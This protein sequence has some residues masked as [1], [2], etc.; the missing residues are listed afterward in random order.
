MAGD[1]TRSRRFSDW[2]GLLCFG[3]LAV[4]TL[5]KMTIASVMLIPTLVHELL[6]GGAFLIR[7]VPRA[8]IR[9]AR[10]RFV[11]YGGTFIMMG[12]SATAQQFRPDWLT[13]T[14]VPALLVA[15]VMLWLFGTIWSIYSIWHLRYAFSIEPAARRLVV[16]GPY[17]FARHPVYA[18]YCAQYM[19][20]FLTLPTVPLAVVLMVW[21]LLAMDRI[22]HEER[23]LSSVFPDYE[24]YRQRV[25]ALGTFSIHPPVQASQS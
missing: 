12:F 5:S 15:G 19:G 10:A 14:N 4:I 13:P 11:S 24:D 3:A 21:S 23:V 17:R 7:D 6:I 25:G 2:V 1:L 20:M 22:R 9:S 8:T 18:G 16:S